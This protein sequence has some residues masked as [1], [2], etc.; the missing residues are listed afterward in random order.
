MS[1]SFM[2]KWTWRPPPQL[3]FS[4]VKHALPSRQSIPL[5]L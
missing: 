3:L 2:Q 5:K 4:H 1:N